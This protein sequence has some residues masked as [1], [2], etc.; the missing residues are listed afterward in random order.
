[1]NAL[2]EL[3]Q[4]LLTLITELV[5]KADAHRDT[6][7]PGYT[8]M[9]P[10]QPITVGKWLDSYANMAARDVERLNQAY[11]NAR[12][13]MPLGSGALAGTP[14]PINRLHLMEQLDF[15]NYNANSLDAVSDRDFVADA[16][17]AMSMIGVHLQ[18]L[19]RRP[20]PVQQSGVRFRHAG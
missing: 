3:K 11:S 18:P 20:D 14:F 6:L 8:H 13:A 5:S 4:A 1:M 16:L 12:E 15:G 10:A 7:M 2:T 17:Y 19:G 9:Q